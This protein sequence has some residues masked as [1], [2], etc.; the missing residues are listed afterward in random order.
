VSVPNEVQTLLKDQ[1][2]GITFPCKSGCQM[3][4]IHNGEDLGGYFAYR[5]WGGLR[6]AVEAAISRNHQLRV[7][8]KRQGRTGKAKF[9]KNAKARSNTGVIGVYGSRYYDERRAKHYFRYL[10]RWS[11]TKGK[12]RIKTFNLTEPY[13]A[14][15]QVHTFRSATHFRKAWEN[16][17]EDFDHIRFKLW[18]QKRLYHPGQPDLPADFWEIREDLERAG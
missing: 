8:H 6:K 17:L 2:F 12:G 1:R 14:D 13:T 18:R 9:R 7:I 3:R 4:F 10:V 5:Q 15:Q 16:E 11:D